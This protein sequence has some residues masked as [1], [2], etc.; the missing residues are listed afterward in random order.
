M[1][2]TEHHTGYK[3]PALTTRQKVQT[4]GHVCIF[5][6]ATSKAQK[7]ILKNWPGVLFVLSELELRH[8]ELRCFFKKATTMSS[9]FTDDFSFYDG[10]QVINFNFSIV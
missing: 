10:F 8:A 3:L 7:I 9:T 2:R 4:A 1:P 5:F 6:W